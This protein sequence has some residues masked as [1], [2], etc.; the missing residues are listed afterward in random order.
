[1]M[2][3]DGRVKTQSHL[4]AKSFS[5]ILLAIALTFLS[6]C[7]GSSLQS[8]SRRPT[9]QKAAAG[10]QTLAGC[11]VSIADGDTVTVLDAANVQHR[12][13]LEGIDAPE[14][15]QPFG[16]KSKESLAVMIFGKDVTVVY[17]KTDQYGR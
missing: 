15:G 3:P 16:S 11:V 6:S 8:E 7:Y 1:M 4:K 12:V 5:P 10:Q 13:R 14:N 17:G 9:Q 2:D